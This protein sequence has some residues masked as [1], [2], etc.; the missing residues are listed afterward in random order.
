MLLPYNL[1]M[2]QIKHPGSFI[3]EKILKPRNLTISALAQLLEVNRSNLSNLI[4]GKISLSKDMASKLESSFGISAENLLTMQLEFDSEQQ[5]QESVNVKARTYVAPFLEIHA[6]D[7][8]LTFTNSIDMRARLAVFLRILIH[9]TT[10]YLSKVDFPGF[11]KTWL[12]W[13]G[14]NSIRF[15]MGTGRIIW[16]G[17]WSR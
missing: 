12:G 5:C 13:L 8:E 9:S 3:R 10:G 4:N 1:K 15:C 6:N 14:R 16:L 7:I 2:K 11:S 17:I